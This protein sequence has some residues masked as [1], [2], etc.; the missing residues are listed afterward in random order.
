MLKIKIKINLPPATLKPL[1]NGEMGNINTQSQERSHHCH[2]LII[3]IKI[4]QLFFML[5]RVIN[6]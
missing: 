4:I 2:S 6:G 5:T 3:L 1:K